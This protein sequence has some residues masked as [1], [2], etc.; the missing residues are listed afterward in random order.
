MRFKEPVVC[1]NP[2]ALE[3]VGTMSVVDGFGEKCRDSLCDHVDPAGS[4]LFRSASCTQPPVIFL[5]AFQPKNSSAFIVE[6]VE[7]KQAVQ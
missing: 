7:K 5:T 2:V 4:L 1:G 6:R 3:R